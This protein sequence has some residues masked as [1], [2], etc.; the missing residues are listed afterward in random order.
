MTQRTGRRNEMG[1]TKEQE[2]A[3]DARGCSLL[4]SAAAG[5]GKTSVLVERLVRILSDSEN[6]VPAD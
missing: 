4:V 6:R 2:T 1:W 3:I 5:S